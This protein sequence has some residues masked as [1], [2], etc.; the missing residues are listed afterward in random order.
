MLFR[1]V[2]VEVEGAGELTRGQREHGRAVAFR[3]AV[4][5]TERQAAEDLGPTERQVRRAGLLGLGG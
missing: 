4:P 1:G 2:A 3:L 5:V